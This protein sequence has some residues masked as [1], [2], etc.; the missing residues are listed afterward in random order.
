MQSFEDQ[1]AAQQAKIQELESMLN[2][3][4]T[5][6]KKE[7]ETA[8]DFL[9]GISILDAPMDT[10]NLKDDDEKEDD[11]AEDE[12]DEIQKQIQQSMNAL[13]EFNFDEAGIIPKIK[14]QKKKLF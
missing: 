10:N 12:F 8:T 13:N 4:S 14:K 1:L 9:I 7:K 11:E 6:L 5:G 2:I 3:A